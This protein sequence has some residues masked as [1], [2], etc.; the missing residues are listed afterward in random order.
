MN[1]T[2]LVQQARLVI[3]TRKEGCGKEGRLQQG[4]TQY[5][6]QGKVQQVRKGIKG[7]GEKHGR[8]GR[9]QQA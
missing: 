3:D 9:T 5:G 7:K 4:K 1:K 8:Q 6:G 2:M